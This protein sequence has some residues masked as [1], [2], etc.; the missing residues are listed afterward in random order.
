MYVRLVTSVPNLVTQQ[1]RPG[2]I[3]KMPLFVRPDIIVAMVNNEDHAPQESICRLKARQTKASV[4]TAKV[5][6]HMKQ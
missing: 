4:L 6:V 1:S 5:I 3:L 2:V